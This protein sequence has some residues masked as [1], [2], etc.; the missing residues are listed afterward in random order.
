MKRGTRTLCIRAELSELDAVRRFI[1]EY[2][3][4]LGLTPDSVYGVVLSTDELITNTVVHGY[5]GRPGPIEIILRP[6][7]DSLVV[8]LRDQAPPFDPT[9]VPA[10]D[11]TLPLELRPAG[12]LGIHLARH[13]MD[14][15]AHSAPPQG[16]NELT[17]VKRGA[18]QA[19][20]EE[21]TGGV[22]G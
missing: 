17:L 15:I 19:H 22:G 21:E 1:E 5:Q 7:G 11:T 2:A 12:G 4:E 8:V 3:T 16:G 6:S 18:V 9:L 14:S 13:F 20:P 10:P